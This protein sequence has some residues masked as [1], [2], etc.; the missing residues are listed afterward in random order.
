VPFGK[1]YTDANIP[2]WAHDFSQYYATLG[3]K[4]DFLDYQVGVG[5]A[6][7]MSTKSASYYPTDRDFARLVAWVTD[8]AQGTKLRV[9]LDSV[10]IGNTVMA[11]MNNTKYHWQDRYA[12][13]LLGDGDYAHLHTMRDA[14]VIGIVFG[15]GQSG[16]DFTCPCDA[17]GDGVTQGVPAGGTPKGELAASSDDDGGYLAAR[18]AAYLSAGGM[19]LG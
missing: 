16:P 14:G 13:W 18:V 5:E 15:F 4:F 2:Q 10:P 19:P 9:V 6:G 8:L 17:A 3:A 11:T 1:N 12:Q 7:K